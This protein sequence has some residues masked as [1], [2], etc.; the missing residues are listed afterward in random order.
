MTALPIT[1]ETALRRQGFTIDVVEAAEFTVTVGTGSIVVPAMMRS[2]LTWARTDPA[3]PNQGAD[4]YLSSIPI[5]DVAYR[6]VLLSHILDRFRTRRLGYNTPDQWMLGFRRWVN[7]NM[8]Y[9][10]QRYRSTAVA[11]PLDDRDATDIREATTH[12]L[13]V[14]SDFPQSLIAGDTDHATDATDRRVADNATDRRT[15]RMQSV[16]ALLNEQRTAYLNVDAEVVAGLENLFLGILDQ[17]E[18]M[19]PDG[20]YG[21]PYRGVRP[22]DWAGW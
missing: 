22:I 2:E 6:P 17:G 13:D 1:L 21:Y 11:L 20:D 7:L 4:F 5:F 19:R 10:N 14:G 9:F 16:A 12:A 15:G 8:P 3:E 18:G